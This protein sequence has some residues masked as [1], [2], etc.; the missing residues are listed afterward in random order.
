MIVARLD[1]WPR[2]WNRSGMDDRAPDQFVISYLN[3]RRAIGAFAMSLPWMMVIGGYLF[4][5]E[6]LLPSLS[7]YYYTNMHDVFVGMLCMTGLFLIAYKGF[8]RIDDWATNFSGVFAFGVALF[9][10]ECKYG[11]VCDPQARV[12]T[13][14]LHAELSA[15]LHLG[16][17]ALLLVTL[18]LI[19]LFLFTK[20]DQAVPTPEKKR[21]N[22]VY[23]LCG[24]GMLL[25]LAI[26]LILQVT[27]LSSFAPLRLDFYVEATC[28][29]FFGFSW[30]TKGEVGPFKDKEPAADLAMAGQ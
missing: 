1:S 21:R 12:G 7:A 3:M 5:G 20:T 22:L 15:K 14:W 13:F 6:N 29:S 4:G 25:T 8:D 28:L 11:A 27:P 9:P 26:F 17:A 16:A 30:L 24:V 10:S 2:L 19:S 18:S 23:R